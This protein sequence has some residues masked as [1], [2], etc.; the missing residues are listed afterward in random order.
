[1]PRLLLLRRLP[2]AMRVLVVPA[3]TRVLLL[4]LLLRIALD[5]PLQLCLPPV[6]ALA[7]SHSFRKA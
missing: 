4:L 7:R 1:M 2:A 5:R 3:R 6:R